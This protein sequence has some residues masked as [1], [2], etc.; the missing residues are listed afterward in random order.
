MTR[1]LDA[2]AQRAQYDPD[3]AVDEH[4]WLGAAID[5]DVAADRFG[6]W[7]AS[8]VVDEN[9]GSPILSRAVFDAL[10]GRAGLPSAWPVGNAG[11][12]HVYGYLLSTTPTPYGLK[13][14]R[15]IDGALARAY[16]L[17][18]DE[19]VPWARRPTLLTRVTR[20]ADGLLAESRVRVAASNGATL[21]LGRA[22]HEGPWAL[23][24][25]VGGRLIT[26]F[27]VASSEAVLT[28]W[29]AA[30]DRLRWNAHAG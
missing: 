17:A 13:R 11:L 15:W 2:V 6:H 16:G 8:T 20:A 18:D 21:A 22:P 7:G 14:D 4:P 12:L 23:A 27:P 26:T 1:T 28:E 3:G 25:A 9:T 29:D 19:F 30:P 5:A 10:H 24:Y